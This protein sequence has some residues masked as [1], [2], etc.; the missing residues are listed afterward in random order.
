VVVGGETVRVHLFVATLGYSRR[1]F[2]QAFRRERQSAWLDG[3]E[4]AFRHFGGVPREVL[5]DNARALVERHDAATREVIFNP[6]LHAFAHYWGFRLRACAPYRARAK[7]KDERGVGYVKGNAIAGHSF[8]SWAAL[9]GNLR[10]WMRE[11]ADKH[12]HGTTAEAPIERFAR[13]E[14]AALRAVDGRPPFGQ[15]RQLVRRVH[16]DYAIEVDTNAYSVPWRLTGETVE[17]VLAGGRISIRHRGEEM[18]AHA[19]TAGRHQRVLDPAHLAGIGR[20]Q[21]AAPAELDMSEDAKA[22]AIAEPELLRP[23]SEYERAIGGGW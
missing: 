16:S 5:L 23:V 20:P 19:E 12:V 18:A 4:A 15:M 8:T 2:A 14:A 1:T 9:E 22:A 6:R 21:P 11:I 10:W 17:V 7:G 3:M 13:A